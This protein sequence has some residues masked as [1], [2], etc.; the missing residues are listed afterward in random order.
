MALI[1]PKVSMLASRTD[2]ELESVYSEIDSTRKTCVVA[3]LLL[4]MLSKL[5]DSLD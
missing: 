3:L 2:T 5:K 1:A 4:H